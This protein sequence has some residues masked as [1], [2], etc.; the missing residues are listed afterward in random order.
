[1][2][3]GSDLLVLPNVWN[4]IGAKILEA[5]GYPAVATA[6]LAVSSALRDRGGR[7]APRVSC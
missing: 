6:S 3:D 4:P 5:E 7:R 2:H 1:M